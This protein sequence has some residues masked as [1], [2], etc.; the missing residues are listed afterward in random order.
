MTPKIVLTVIGILMLVHGIAFFFGA[1]SLAKM[2]VPEISEQALQV[3][4]GAHEIV[5]IF[6]VF[7]GIVLIFSRDIDTHSAKKVLT[8][9]G[10]G[11]LIWTAGIIY[12]MITLKEIPEQAPPAP[13]LII[14]AL[15]TAWTFYVALVKKE[16]TEETQ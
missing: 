1:S 4:V 10:I 16:D 11:S 13:M 7:L 5:A 3:S 14:A 9:T 8:G 15:L 2:G 12:H 6:S